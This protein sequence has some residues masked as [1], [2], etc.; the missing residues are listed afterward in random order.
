MEC[1]V[2]GGVKPAFRCLELLRFDHM[3]EW[4]EWS[5]EQDHGDFPNLPDITRIIP[6]DYFPRLERLRC[7]MWM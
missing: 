1:E 6:L 5:S 4:Q 3:R 7:I 2:Y